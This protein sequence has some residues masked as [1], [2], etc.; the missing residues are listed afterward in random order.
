MSRNLN[1]FDSFAMGVLEG[2]LQRYCEGKLENVRGF[3]G[4]VVTETDCGGIA[5]AVSVG[6]HAVSEAGFKKR[7]T[8]SRDVPFRS[9]HAVAYAEIWINQSAQ[10]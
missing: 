5:N 10:I 7:I 3:P 6:T 4:E 8:R 1:R 9:Q 2:P